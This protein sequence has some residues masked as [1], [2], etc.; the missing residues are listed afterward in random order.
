MSRYQIILPH[1][2]FGNINQLLSICFL[3]FTFLWWYSISIQ[4]VLWMTVMFTELSEGQCDKFIYVFTKYLLRTHYRPGMY[5]RKKM[6]KYNYSLLL[7]NIVLQWM[8]DWINYHAYSVPTNTLIVCD[9][10][11]TLPRSFICHQRT[12]QN[13]SREMI[14]TLMVKD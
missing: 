3:N 4:I 13:N 14:F 6:H 12:S 1:S 11:L 7:N 9:F 10:N 2:G 8:G 5:Q